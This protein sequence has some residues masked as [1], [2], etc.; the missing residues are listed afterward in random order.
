MTLVLPLS[1]TSL[2][3][4]AGPSR[5]ICL[6]DL[7]ELA[8]ASVVNKCTTLANIDINGTRA[9]Q[10][11]HIFTNGMR[12]FLNLTESCNCIDTDDVITVLN[13]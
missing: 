13:A 9:Q 2:R 7:P 6:G 3:L 8:I 1:V 11:E 10:V 5:A 4:H 12:C